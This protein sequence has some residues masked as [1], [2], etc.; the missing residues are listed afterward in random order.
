[1]VTLRLLFVRGFWMAFGIEY[2]FYSYSR[3]QHIGAR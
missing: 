2:T 1:V 3:E